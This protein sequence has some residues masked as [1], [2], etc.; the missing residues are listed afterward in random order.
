MR[1]RTFIIALALLLCFGVVV[2]G[3][4]GPGRGA[5]RSGGEAGQPG[6]NALPVAPAE[7]S[8]RY[9]AISVGGRLRP[10]IKIEHQA[11]ANGMVLSVSVREGQKVGEGTPLFTVE[12]D[13]ITGSFKPVVETA[14][15]AGIV[16][17]VA[18]QKKDEIR[19][20][21]TGVVIIGTEGYTLEA[22]ISD[23]DAF[24][25]AVGEPVV[26]RT[27]DGREISGR[28][29]S[30]SPEPDY[31]TGLFFL[32]FRFPNSQNVAIGQFVMVDLPV[33]RVHG[34]FIERE[35]LV[36][37]YGTFFLWIVDEENVLHAREVKTGALFGDQIL[38][39]E[40]L[41]EGER[42]LTRL[43]GREREG[44]KIGASQE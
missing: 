13:D 11:T 43:T 25:V 28:L 39:T 26:G 37:R 12:R 16:S 9:N 15:I 32:T 27:I 20:G 21:Q 7:P 22:N 14:R 23:K 4:Q 36:R 38:I 29:L 41:T 5:G 3:Q 6:E 19:S 34:I 2:W 33:D 30:R 8:E 24:K 31:E 42:Y 1:I 18:V 40:G 44:M 35:L 10:E 17:E